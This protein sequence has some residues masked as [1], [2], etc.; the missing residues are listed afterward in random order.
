MA[1]LCLLTDKDWA[2]NHVVMRMGVG[3]GGVR[4]G[5]Q[6]GGG[7]GVK[8]VLHVLLAERRVAEFVAMLVP[9]CL[10]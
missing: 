10:V 6:V 1:C 8:S 4:G 7:L 2:D 5:V 3:R 9:V